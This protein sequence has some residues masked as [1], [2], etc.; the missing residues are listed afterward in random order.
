MTADISTR[1]RTRH[2]RA[3][4]LWLYAV[5]ALVLA[6]VLVGGATRLT[7]CGLSITEWQPVMGV[8]PPLEQQPM[9]GRVRKISSHPA[10]PRT[11]PRHEP[12]CVQDDLLV[13]MDAPACSADRSALRSCCRF[14][15]FSGAAG[16]DLGLRPRLWF[17]FGLGALQGAVGWWMVA[18]GLA[19][20]VEVS[21][22]RLA[23]HL[24]L[25]CLIYVALI[26]TA[27]RRDNMRPPRRPLR[28][29][30]ASAPMR[31]LFSCWRKSISAHWSPVC[32]PAMSITPGR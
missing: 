27:Q 23:T 7:E 17:I 20:R 15:G 2:A 18:S 1:N 6:M 22:Y 26:W 11:Q 14:C 28:R 31:F 25:A 10:I 21:Q 16:S 19:G 29:A 4:R 8:L 5:A 9:A 24:L 32:A 30:S 12:R 13:G 3:I